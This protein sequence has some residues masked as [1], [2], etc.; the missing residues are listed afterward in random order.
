MTE[1]CIPNKYMC[2]GTRDCDDGSDE[3][4]CSCSDDEFQ[5]SLRI[6]GGWTYQNLHECISLNSINDGRIDCWSRK[7]E[8]W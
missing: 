2:D 4:E 3:L 8:A 5:C 7:D 6:D 1:V